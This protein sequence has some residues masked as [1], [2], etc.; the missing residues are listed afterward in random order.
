MSTQSS[1]DEFILSLGWLLW[2]SYKRWAS[3]LT[4]C[5]YVN[6]SPYRNLSTHS[7]SVHCVWSFTQQHVRPPNHAWCYTWLWSSK[8]YTPEA[9]CSDTMWIE[10]TVN[11]LTWFQSDC[12]PMLIVG[13]FSLAITLLLMGPSPWLGFSDSELLVCKL[14]FILVTLEIPCLVLMVLQFNSSLIRSFWRFEN[15]YDCIISD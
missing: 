1:L 6:V 9:K 14:L 2:F 12:S 13:F 7:I 5:N 3:S 15:F 8:F 11:F 10:R 4:W